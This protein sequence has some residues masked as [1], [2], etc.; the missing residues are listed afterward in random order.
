[1]LETHF[2]FVFDV[3]DGH[4]DGSGVILIR[5]YSCRKVSRYEEMGTPCYPGVEKLLE[6]FAK[7]ITVT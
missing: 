7:D 3:Q 1:M 5:A 4:W 2:V 6:I